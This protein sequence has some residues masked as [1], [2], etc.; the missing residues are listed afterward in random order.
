MLEEENNKL[1]KLLAEK[2]LISKCI[3]RSNKKKLMNGGDKEA[4]KAIIRFLRSCGMKVRRLKELFGIPRSS[5]YE[6]L[7]REER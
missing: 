3:K 1:K 5:L 4:M 2:R 6:M 7:K